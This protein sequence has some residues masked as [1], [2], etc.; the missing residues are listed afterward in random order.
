[1]SEAELLVKLIVNSFFTKS[2]FFKILGMLLEVQPA[3]SSYINVAYT[4]KTKAVT[5]QNTYQVV[6]QKQIGAFNSDFTFEVYFPN[7]MFIT[8]QNFKSLA[9]NN[10]VGYNSSLSTDKIFVLQFIKE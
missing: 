2:G 1:V 3:S 10:A 4:L 7:N 6:I 9:K 5:G 8:D